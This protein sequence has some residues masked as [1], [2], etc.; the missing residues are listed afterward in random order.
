MS[1][2]LQSTIDQSELND[3]D[4]FDFLVG[5][6]DLIKRVDELHATEDDDS[7]Y[8]FIIWL[9]DPFYTQ[10]VITEIQI[11]LTLIGDGKRGNWSTKVHSPTDGIIVVASSL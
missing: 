11:N 5:Q 7:T 8:V 10:R 1:M 4:R 3:P 2:L 6:T 9:N